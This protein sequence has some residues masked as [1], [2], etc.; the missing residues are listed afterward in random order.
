M[1]ARSARLL[2][3]FRARQVFPLLNSLRGSGT[4]QC[5]SITDARRSL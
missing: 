4:V 2:L 1:V 3:D 5:P